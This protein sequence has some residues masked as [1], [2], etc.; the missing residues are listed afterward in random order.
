MPTIKL[1]ETNSYIK[2]FT[3]TVISCD[4]KDGE[5]FV[6]LDRTA[7]FAEGGGQPADTG[8]IE[9]A[10]VFDVQIEDGI[11]FH[12]VDKTLQIGKT[13][14]CAIDWDT[15][16]SRMQNHSAEHLVSGIIHNLYGYNNVAA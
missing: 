1:Y 8:K 13:V 12:K 16:F 15:R 11:V 4:E 5:F 3:A 6:V 2:N 7:F 10:N 14:E 9:E